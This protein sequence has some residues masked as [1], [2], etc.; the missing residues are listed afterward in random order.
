MIETTVVIDKKE[1]TSILNGLIET[2]KDGEEGF[3]LAAEKVKQQT[4]KT[5]FAEY[6]LQRAKFAKALQIV[7]SGNGE[8]PSTSGHLGGALHRGWISL[9]EAL[10]RDEDKAIIDE[11]EA[12]EDAAVKSYREAL[13]KPLPHEVRALVETQFVAVQESHAAIRDLKHSRQ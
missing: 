6:N 8:E 5:L 10:A 11:C 13:A 3:R 9:K 12:G 1:V 2:C 4:L 7:V